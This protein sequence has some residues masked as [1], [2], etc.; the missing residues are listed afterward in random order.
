MASVELLFGP[1]LIGTYANAILYGIMLVQIFVYF[2]S[3][4]NDATWIRR[5]IMYLLIVETIN[6]GFDIAMMYQPLVLEYATPA[7]TKFFPLGLYAEPVVTVA[8]STPVQ[9]FIAW[10]IRLISQSTLLALIICF[11]SIISLGG[12]VW[13]THT[14]SVV[15]VFARKPELHWPAVMW[16]VATAVVDVLITISLTVSL[17]RRKTGY[18]G[19][20]NAIRKIIRLTVQTGL[21]TAL[22]AILDVVCFLV[23]PHSAINFAWDF[24]LSKL[25]TNALMSSL[26]AR[27]G[28][29]TTLSNTNMPPNALFS[30]DRELMRGTQVQTS[31][32]TGTTSR[33]RQS[34]TASYELGLPRSNRVAFGKHDGPYGVTITKEVETLR[35]DSVTDIR[36]AQVY[37]G[38]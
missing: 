24:P 35:E 29:N 9:I 7:A 1:M 33:T 26:N 4:K 20:D 21:I 38:V 32:Q 18:T 31:S 17:S 22:F 36:K 37:N 30:D 6:T 12:A 15:R 25:Y 23:L 5:F 11:F 27:A 13:L 19:T 14:I 3:Y 34:A 10:R 2:Q 8:I 28:W 16:L